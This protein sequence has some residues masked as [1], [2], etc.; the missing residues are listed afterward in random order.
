[1]KKAQKIETVKQLTEKLTKAKTI[2]LTD[3]KGITHQQLEGLRKS[4]AKVEAEYVVTK[5]TLLS[6]AMKSLNKAQ[7]KKSIEQLGNELQ[8]ST[9]TLFAYGDEIA[10]VKI[11]ATFI[12][13]TSLP[14]IKLGLF[15][16]D[17]A[18][19]TDFIKLAALPTKEVL[20]GTL[21]GR[22]SGPLYGLHNAAS[23]NIRKL[24]YALE[25]VKS[26]KPAN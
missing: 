5:N 21:V 6:R 23:W 20:L 15:E 3:Y 8:N 14:K 25:A 19:E 9:A 11:L 17:I 1:M 26:K 10:A 2:F 22:L 4:L 12:K 18:T 16:G 13:N 24:V 7:D